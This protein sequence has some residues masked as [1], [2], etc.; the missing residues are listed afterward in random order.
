[1]LFNF[2]ISSFFVKQMTVEILCHSSGWCNASKETF[3]TFKQKTL[4]LTPEARNKLLLMG[5]FQ[6]YR[7]DGSNKQPTSSLEKLLTKYNKSVFDYFYERDSISKYDVPQ[8]F[9]IPKPTIEVENV[10][11]SMTGSTD[12]ES[13]FL[14]HLRQIM[15]T[16][17][18]T[19]VTIVI[20]LTF[21][22]SC[23][24][25]DTYLPVWKNIKDKIEEYNFGSII[26]IENPVTEFPKGINQLPK[27]LF[28][29]IQIN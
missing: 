17:K 14:D 11:I 7:Y 19:I 15:R 1:M 22:N 6:C 26:M 23:K 13:R 20:T 25:L 24:N 29:T 18:N 28:S 27:V 4:I 21:M 12:F 8:T 9:K 2:T 10:N 16:R 3:E 5:E